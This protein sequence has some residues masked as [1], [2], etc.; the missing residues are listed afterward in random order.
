MVK[1]PIL[2]Q[3]RWNDPRLTFCALFQLISVIILTQI[4]SHAFFFFFSP[5]THSSMHPRSQPLTQLDYQW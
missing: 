5:S 1:Q 4:H 3:L 2:D